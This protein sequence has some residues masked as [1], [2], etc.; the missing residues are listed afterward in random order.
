LEGVALNFSGATSV[1]GMLA[2]GPSSTGWMSVRIRSKVSGRRVS[3]A[4][5]EPFRVGQSLAQH[6]VRVANRLRREASAIGPAVVEQVR[7]DRLDL[8]RRQ[9]LQLSVAESCA[10]PLRRDDLAVVGRRFEPLLLTRQPLVE[11]V[12]DLDHRFRDNEPRS[13]KCWAVASAFS[14]SRFV[15]KPCRSIWRRLTF[16][17]FTPASTRSAHR[18]SF[19][20]IEPLAMERQSQLAY[21]LCGSFCT[22]LDVSSCAPTTTFRKTPGRWCPGRDLN[23]YSTLVEGGFKLDKWCP[24]GAALSVQNAVTWGVV[25]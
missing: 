19:L 24:P 3:P 6:R 7:V 20:K 13:T 22:P 11:E 18:S 9:R 16:S 4:E 23:P 15:A 17:R 14:A 5:T 8:Q 2:P 25:P 21:L 10:D 1:S 12:V